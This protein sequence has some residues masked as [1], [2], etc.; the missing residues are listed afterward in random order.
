[1]TLRPKAEPTWSDEER[2]T[3]EGRVR[4]VVP[5]VA[6]ELGLWQSAGSR[7]WRALGL[8][9]YRTETFKL[10]TDPCV[11]D[12]VHD[13]VDLHLDPPERALVFCVDEKSR[14]QALGAR[15]RCCR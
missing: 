3:F 13:V 6:K 11:V 7:I 9:P 10:S 12:K 4:P 2:A 5:R 1:M 15:C 14:I 8:Q